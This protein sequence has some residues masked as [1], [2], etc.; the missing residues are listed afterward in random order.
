MSVFSSRR[1]SRSPAVAIVSFAAIGFF[2]IPVRDTALI[3]IDRG[4]F[5]RIVEHH[6]GPML[7]VARLIVER[8]QRALE[9]RPSTGS[10]AAFAV[11]AFI[12]RNASAMPNSGE[13][14][15]TA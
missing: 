13:S 8:Y 12:R 9:P 1:A 14:T 11:V 3:R 10:L 5:D 6:P 2:V 15:E 4:A 7:R